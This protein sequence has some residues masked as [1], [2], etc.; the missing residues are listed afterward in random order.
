MVEKSDSLTYSFQG[1][2]ISIL[3]NNLAGAKIN[4]SLDGKEIENRYP[5]K[6]TEYRSAFYQLSGLEK[7]EHKACKR[8][9]LTY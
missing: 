3:G 2:G 6:A 7:K 5:V 1:T 9:Y 8:R 4:I